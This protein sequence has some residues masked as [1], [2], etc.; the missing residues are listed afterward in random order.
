[1][2]SDTIIGAVQ[3]VTKKWA[4][5]RKKEERVASA[6]LNRRRAMTRVYR[7]TA[8]DAAWEVMEEAYLKASANGTLP[9][10]ARQI[11]YAG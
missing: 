8:K 2:K 11:M 10:L 9:A 5:Q 6:R 1:M 7:I 3:G 4:K